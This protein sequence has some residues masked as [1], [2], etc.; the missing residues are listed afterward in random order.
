M[1]PSTH[2]KTAPYLLIALL[3]MAFLATAGLLVLTGYRPGAMPFIPSARFSD[4]I[5]SHLPAAAYLRETFATSETFALWRETTFAGAPFAAN[6]LNKTAYPPQ[7]MAFVVPAEFHLN[8][9]ISL[10]L[11]IAAL[12]MAWWL[13]RLGVRPVV[14]VF[15]AL[16]YMLSPRLIAHLGAGHLDIVYAMAWLPAV[17]ASVH[18]LCAARRTAWGVLALSM[19]TALMVLGDVRIGFFGVILASLYAG[20]EVIRFRR[21][22]TGIAAGVIALIVFLTLTA[23]LTI[24]LLAWTP[25]LSRAAV[26][27]VEA[28]IFA[29]DP[30]QFLGLIAPL[31]RGNPETLT[32]LG[33]SITI[34]AAGA[35]IS[36]LRRRW[37][38]VVALIGFAWYA[39]GAFGG[40]WT[41]LT[42]V[43][44]PLLWFRVPSRAW[45]MVTLI[46]VVLA[47][48]GLDALLR[49]IERLRVVRRSALIGGVVIALLLIELMVSARNWLEWRTDDDWLM[50]YVP[51]AERLLTLEPDRL[52]APAYSLPQHVA[53]LYHFQLFGGVDP[54]QIADVTE[55]IQAAGGAAS[56]G[57]SVVQP[58]LNEV[59]GDDLTTAN[60]RA[61][62]DLEALAAWSVSHVIAPYPILQPG[63]TR[64]DEVDGVTVYANDRYRAAPVLESIPPAP[65]R[66]PADAGVQPDA[67]R[68]AE[69]HEYTLIAYAVSGFGFGAWGIAAVYFTRRRQ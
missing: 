55:A 60:Q 66:W 38:W 31:Q 49:R 3:V 68:V 2:L 46:A 4:A 6:P 23:A 50:P 37:L 33:Y 62:L 10:H 51:L 20:A 17:L 57:Y 27:P 24:P 1:S 52:Y 36:Q 61:R 26:T 65:P 63:L 67:G 22:A 64:I 30:P 56:G 44:P 32:F 43:F 34:L 53:Q 69:L 7:W 25:Y 11:M 39:M 28:G 42:S 13:S 59:V 47:C 14:Q 40:L 48:Y 29:L 54:F 12:S 5:T 45:I 8:I 58:P 19:T 41:A 16:A 15:G 18:V 21:I 9:L 35:A